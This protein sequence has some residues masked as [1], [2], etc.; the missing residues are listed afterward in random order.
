MKAFVWT[1]SPEQ[2]IVQALIS[3]GR[4]SPTCFH[5]APN[6]PVDN[7]LVPIDRREIGPPLKQAKQD[8]MVPV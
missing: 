5:K 3:I 7:S 8:P 4:V 1:N 2:V 6:F